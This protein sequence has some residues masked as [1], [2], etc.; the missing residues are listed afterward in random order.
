[1][2]ALLK[3]L[4]GS[5]NEQDL[6]GLAEALSSICARA[7]SPASATGEII[8][9]L[10]GAQPAQQAA[11]LGVLSAVGGEKALASVRAALSDPHPEVQEAA[12]RALADWPDSSSA[13]DLLRLV[14]ATAT[15]RPRDVAFRGYV[16]LARESE[17]NAAVSLK[18]LTEAAA[19]ASGPEEKRLVIAGLADTQTVESLQ[20]IT[21]HLA[22][23]AVANEA[24]AAAVK[25]AEKL[26]AKYA[27][28]IRES[29]LQVLRFVTSSQVLDQARNRMNE[30]KLPV[31]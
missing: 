18:M 7:G 13:P 28:N 8:A 20:L 31:P 22:D 19:S 24:G 21:P 2:P 12:I 16:R 17:T 14:R 23:P 11:L 26:D 5:S 3:Q 25:V 4:L 10:A 1:V 29:L 15:G 6:A 30:L 9:A 27:A